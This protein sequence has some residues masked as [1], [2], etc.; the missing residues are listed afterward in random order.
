MAA[1]PPHR[2]N[3][4][5]PIEKYYPWKY[6]LPFEIHNRR[7]YF[8]ADKKFVSQP[9]HLSLIIHRACF[10]TI[11]VCWWNN[12]HA[13][14]NLCKIIHKKLSMRWRQLCPPSCQKRGWRDVRG[15]D[16]LLFRQDH[17]W[18]NK[19]GAGRPNTLNHKKTQCSPSSLSFIRDGHCNSCAIYYLIGIS[20]YYVGCCVVTCLVCVL[21]GGIIWAMMA[22]VTIYGCSRQ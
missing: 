21:W 19:H 13:N 10:G 20:K 8:H 1:H 18:G 4:L 6:P 9:E 3:I 7:C 16:D 2:R 11:V 5:P 15:D 17:D 12:V 14:H 22:V